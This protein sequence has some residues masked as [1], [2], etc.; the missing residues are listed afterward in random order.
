MPRVTD[1]REWCLTEGPTVAVED[2]IRDG[3]VHDL[4]S[5]L[6]EYTLN[7]LGWNDEDPSNEVVVPE[8]RRIKMMGVWE[9]G[10]TLFQA[11]TMLDL[12]AFVKPSLESY[13]AQWR[14]GMKAAWGEELDVGSCSYRAADYFYAKVTLFGL[15][16]SPGDEPD[17]LPR[18][19]DV[20]TWAYHETRDRGW[21]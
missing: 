17:S 14:D 10:D 7:E 9:L 15:V 19:I 16:Q 18:R 5:M 2:S 6:V 1:W 8:L 12:G 4:D 3:F 20:D 21:R 11:Y 13:A